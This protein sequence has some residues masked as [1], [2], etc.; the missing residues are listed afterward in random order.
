MTSAEIL[1]LLKQIQ[2]QK[3]ES[4]TL[5]L[6]AAQHGCPKRLYDTLSA[7]SNQD[8][9]GVILF[10]V[11]ETEGFQECGVYNPQDL[12]QHVTE[13]CDQMYPV[14]RPVFSIAEYSEKLFVTAEIP[15]IDAAERPCY[16]VG[17]GR[18]AGS[19]IRVGDAD[20]PMTEYEV[21]SYEAFR[22]K[23]QDDIRP[24]NRATLLALDQDNL[25]QYL[26]S[27]KSGKPNLTALKDKQI[28]ELMSMT[29]DGIPTLA[30]VLLFSPYPQ[31]YFPQ[32]C[33]TAL[34]IDG[35]EIGDIGTGGERFID[36]QRIEGGLPQMLD[37]ALAFV[38]KNIK[39]AF[40][41]NPSSGQ[42]EEQTEYPILAVRE[43][44]LNA[45]VHRDYSIHTEGMPIQLILYRDRFELRSPG[46]LYGRIRLDQLGHVQPDT[47]NPVLAVAM[48]VLHQTENRYSGIPTMKR[49]LA[50]FGLPEPEFSIERDNF[51]VRFRKVQEAALSGSSA[52]TDK[53]VML[54]HIETIEERILL[55]C[56]EPRSRQEIA[57]Y[58]GLRSAYYIHTKYLQP[59]IKAGKLRYTIPETPGSH[60]QRFQTVLS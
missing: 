47:R 37:A 46:G 55:Y 41:F 22:K 24:V 3:C 49:E 32:L 23:Y 17:K 40:R 58:L 19:Y 6:K 11:N 35:T 29:R 57:D 51:V 53:T 1:E 56:A 48:E 14:V 39:T 54:P 20:Q 59:L 5:E 50:A 42:R 43:A 7:F 33:I 27:L 60:R 15:P 2:T 52:M 13:Q 21:Y 8:E 34:S 25:N 18:L 44:V 9:G 28:L 38:R 30:A 26:N 10:G 12:I 4:Q 36:N 16:Y 31:A 45:L